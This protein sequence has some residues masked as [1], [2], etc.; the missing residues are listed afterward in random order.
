MG[1]YLFSYGTLQ[2]EKVQIELFG[3]KLIGTKDAVRG[4]KIST[5][6]IS[7][8]SVVSK[9]EQ[10]LHL[11]AVPATMHD[12]I[13]GMVLELSP[14]ELEAAD[15]YETADYKRIAVQLESGKQA[16]VYVAAH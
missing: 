6:V 4:F 13:E 15:A 12:R 7:D 9:S 14:R 8:E 11:I 16:W 10:S 3:R 1:E 2:K 5:I